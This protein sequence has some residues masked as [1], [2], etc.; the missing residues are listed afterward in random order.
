[1][2]CCSHGCQQQGLESQ[3][4]YCNDCFENCNSKDTYK[5]DE[6]KEFDPLG[7]RQNQACDPP[8]DNLFDIP[9]ENFKW[10]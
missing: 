6:W 2:K 7:Y 9:G 5:S 1:M 3:D 4:G 10:L 8:A